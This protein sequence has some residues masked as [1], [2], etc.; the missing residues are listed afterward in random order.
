[1]DDKNYMLTYH[2][3]GIG[4]PEG[5]SFERTESLGMKLI[6]GLTQQLN[7]NVE[8]KRGDGTTFVVTF[9]RMQKAGE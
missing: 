4:I 1:M 5:I 8:L 7:G 9:P 6:Y 2:D 3:N